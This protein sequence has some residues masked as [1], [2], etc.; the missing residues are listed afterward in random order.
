MEISLIVLKDTITTDGTPLA[1][2]PK[3]E[4]LNLP[5]PPKPP[6]IVNGIELKYA[7]PYRET[8]PRPPTSI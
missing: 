5:I 1:K 6:K 2:V 7:A 3:P 8:P 4:P